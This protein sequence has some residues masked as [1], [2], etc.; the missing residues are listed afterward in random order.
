[1][2]DLHLRAGNAGAL[3]SACPFLRGEDENGERIWLTSGEGFS[4]DIIGPVVITPGEYDE[5]GTEITPPV[6][7]ERFHVNLRCTDEIAAQVPDS[8]KVSP[9]TPIRVWA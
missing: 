9:S 5:D 8:F 3:A 4:L 2:I 1:M 6:L 7:D